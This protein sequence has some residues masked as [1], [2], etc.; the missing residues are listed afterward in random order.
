MGQ[1]FKAMQEM[2]TYI[3][4]DAWLHF[5]HE[6]TI[7]QIRSAVH[8]IAEGCSTNFVFL[9]NISLDLEK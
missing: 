9:A 1:G 6:N 7:S 5:Q 4:T 2:G 3:A 8:A